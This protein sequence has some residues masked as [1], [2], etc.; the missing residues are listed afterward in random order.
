VQS[1]HPVHSP[2]TYDRKPIV[3]SPN[4][5]AF[6]LRN[7]RKLLHSPPAEFEVERPERGRTG[8]KGKATSVKGSYFHPRAFE[9]CEPEPLDD[10]DDAIV[11][12]M[13]PPLLAR[14][15]SFSSEDDD[16]SDSDSDADVLTT[17]PDAKLAT[18]LPKVQVALPPPPPEPVASYACHVASLLRDAT[19]EDKQRPG[20][21]RTS[22]Q[23]YR[24]RDANTPLDIEGCLGGF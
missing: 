21:A 22:K 1:T 6:P 18:A 12:L 16:S 7:D 14:R 20:L 5:C 23:V 10:H 11:P 2:R 3:V 13:P 9:A 4:S 15:S 8:R 17:P 19:V 24:G